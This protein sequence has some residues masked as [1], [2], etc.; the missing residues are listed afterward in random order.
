MQK[1]RKEG[2]TIEERVMKNVRKIK[3]VLLKFGPPIF[4]CNTAAYL[5]DNLSLFQDC[6]IKKNEVFVLL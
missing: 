5:R 1:K 3:V 4:G 6:M 2:K